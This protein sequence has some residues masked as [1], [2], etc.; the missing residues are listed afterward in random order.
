MRNFYPVKANLTL[1]FISAFSILIISCSKSQKPVVAPQEPVTI[2]AFAPAKA[3][4][5]AVVTITGTNF[6]TVA[7]NNTVTFNGVTAKI[8][9]VTATQIVVTVPATAATGK[10][11][12][13][14]NGKKA[15][16]A[17]NFTVTSGVMSDY[18]S[19]GALDIDQIKFD[20]TGRMFGGDGKKIYEIQPNDQPIYY[21]PTDG[22]TGFAVDAQDNFYIPVQTTIVKVSSEKNVSVLAGS[23]PSAGIADGTGADARFGTSSLDLAKDA[24]GN[25]YFLGAGS[26]RKVSPAGVVTTL[27]GTNTFERGYVDGIGSAAKFGY[28]TRE[29]TD[30]SGNLY[31][32]DSDHFRI[33]K[34][35]PEGVVST[36][37]GNGTFGLT[38]GEGANAQMFGPQSLVS[39]ADGNIFFSD[40]DFENH[41]YRIRML[42]KLGQVITLISGNTTSGIVNGALGTATTNRPL[43]LAFDATGN[44]YIVN[45]G[46]HKISKVTFN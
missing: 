25:L 21:T 28:L 41:H 23:Y 18:A 4:P 7:A 22:F 39:D 24:T 35:T 14:S 5:N 6:N 40:A 10:I 27:A 36:V 44:L 2:T 32:V 30:P 34:I 31:V 38:D 37:I 26:I 17:T 8:N 33:R 16:S 45:S 11:E 13:L 12:L 9:S 15:A 20:G 43:G 1:A 19:F 3:L 29:T 46:V 42:N